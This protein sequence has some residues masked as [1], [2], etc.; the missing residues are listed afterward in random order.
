MLVK[1]CTYFERVSIEGERERT[2][3]TKTFLNLKLKNTEF[4][5]F[6]LN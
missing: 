1:N 6:L 5:E 3:C 4:M 2:P